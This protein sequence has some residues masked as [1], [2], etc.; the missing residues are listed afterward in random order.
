MRSSW[1]GIVGLSLVAIAGCTD[2]QLARFQPRDHNVYL[3]TEAS[4]PPPIVLS[5]PLATIDDRDLDEH[6][7][8][9]SGN[10]RRA[11]AGSEAISGFIHIEL[12][13][14]DNNV[15][16]TA[17]ASLKP[18]T[19][20]TDAPSEYKV[21]IWT[22]EPLNTHVRAVF[23]D[24]RDIG[25]YFTGTGGGGGGST[26]TSSGFSGNY[27]RGSTGGAVG[28]GFGHGISGTTGVSG[29]SG[30]GRISMPGY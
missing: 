9:V 12:L 23:I 22:P 28:G 13:D 18:G 4:A 3:K 20:N 25:E 7:V 16:E 30:V 27:T 5:S 17:I 14:K 11:M 21:A 2:K 1:I 24:Q 29:V 8:T 6:E 15:I 10:A 26:G 19:L